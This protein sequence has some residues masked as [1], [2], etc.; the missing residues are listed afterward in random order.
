VGGDAHLT[1]FERPDRARIPVDGRTNVDILR[2]VN[3]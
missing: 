1:D 2:A 3:R